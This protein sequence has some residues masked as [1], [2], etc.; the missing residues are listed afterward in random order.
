MVVERAKVRRRKVMCQRCPK[1][2]LWRRA[3]RALPIELSH[4]SDVLGFANKSSSLIH[5]RERRLRQ[6]GEVSDPSL[7]WK[8]AFEWTFREDYAGK[9]DLLQL[10]RDY[11]CFSGL[12]VWRNTK[13]W[14][15]KMEA[16]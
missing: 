5:R 2:G 12:H 1:H 13:K 14:T 6:N 11:V 15:W 7:C 8:R 9:W 16:D 3:N 10:V 4:K